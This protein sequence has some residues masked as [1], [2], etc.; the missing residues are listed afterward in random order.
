MRELTPEEA[1]LLDDI[2]IQNEDTSVNMKFDRDE[3]YQR[4]FIAAILSDPEISEKAIKF[5]KGDY[6][7]NEA[8]VIVMDIVIDVY[9]KYQG[10]PNKEVI[11]NMLIDRLAE[12]DPSVI[13]HLRTEIESVY[14]YYIPEMVEVK[15]MMDEMQNWVRLQ[16]VRLSLKDC[17]SDMDITADKIIDNLK[18]SIES[19][20]SM[21]KSEEI[22][23]S[24][25]DVLANQ[26]QE[27]WLIQHWL[28]FG[29][30]GM[31]SGDP[32][33]GKSHIIA[34]IITSIVSTGKFAR[35]DVPKCAVLIIDAE[36][37]KRVFSKRLKNAL[38][39][40]KEEAPQPYLRRVDSSKI[41]LPIPLN[42]APEVIR[43]MIQDTKKETE[44]EKVF[45]V[46]DTLRSVFAVDEMENA[47]M[48]NL[49]YPLQR[50]AQEENAAI[51][52]LHH[53][54]KSGANY[55]GQTSI[56]GA[57]DYLWMW[58]SD[59]EHG[60]GKLAMKGT[61]DEYAAPMTFILTNGK[62]QYVPDPETGGVTMSKKKNDIG[63]M[64][65][66][67]LS[68]GNSMIQTELIMKIQNM[69]SDVSA[70]GKDTIR[71]MIQG[72]VGTL[73]VLE[74]G[75]NNSSNYKLMASC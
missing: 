18:T 22:Y 72:Y 32:F 73:I 60:I 47:D 69:W 4:R 17:Y 44:Q 26:E 56:A 45:V 57:L 54:P 34:E 11:R 7:T 64:M 53:R 48:K 74:K 46:I 67:I 50:I 20:K 2:I 36:N 62:N 75:K 19:D 40:G 25:A 39:E 33:S 29:S 6:F 55:S 52:I 70:P 21:C 28:E 58:T 66:V 59:I 3:T 23:Q 10:H 42:T 27:E 65:E 8:H 24:W 31:L 35:Y 37:K 9:K 13:L 61:R 30:L 1:A 16:A 5:V 15:Y 43:T 12:R 38:G 14:D 68:D 71:T 41:Q 49:L 51:L 63:E